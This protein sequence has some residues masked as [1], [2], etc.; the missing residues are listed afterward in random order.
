VL[1]TLLAG[2]DRSDLVLGV[3]PLL[4]KGH[5]ARRAHVFVRVSRMGV[6]EKKI[7]HRCRSED[8]VRTRGER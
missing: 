8:G 5:G 2:V 3:C 6:V 4:R 1:T 7:H